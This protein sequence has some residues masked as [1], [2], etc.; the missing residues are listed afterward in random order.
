MLL[1][2]TAEHCLNDLLYRH[3]TGALPM[4]ITAIASNHT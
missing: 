1:V 2:S 4:T 3:R